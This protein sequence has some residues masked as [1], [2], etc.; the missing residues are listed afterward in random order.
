MQQQDMSKS[1]SGLNTR[2]Q[3]FCSSHS[4]ALSD[5]DTTL[6]VVS[7]HRGI[8]KQSTDSGISSPLPSDSFKYLTWHELKEHDVRGNQIR[9]PRVREGPSEEELFFRGEEEA[10]QVRKQVTEKEKWQQRQQENW[11]NCAD[12]G[13]AYQLENFNRILRRLIRVERLWLVD[14]SLTDLS[15]IR[16]PRCKELNVSKNH[17]TSFKQLPK[18][19][20]IRHLSL[21]D[22]NI[23]TLS[24][25]SDLRSTPLES[26]VLMRNPCE[27]KEHYRELVFS[28]LPNLRMLDGVPKLPEDCPPPEI[29]SLS[30]ICTI[31]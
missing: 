8:Q 30:K 25:I 21:A 7:R 13:D 20:Q 31:L 22:N 16:L 11:E 17:F 27:F 6:P 10:L 26:L 5:S 28:N 3:R 29:S 23:E 1:S 4:S 24:G 9:C 12:L 2:S 18:I 14:N 15:A 19:P